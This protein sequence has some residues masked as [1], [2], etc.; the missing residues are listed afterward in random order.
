MV[1]A[2]MIE[3]PADIQREMKLFRMG[4]MSLPTSYINFHR[5][6]ALKAK[7][8]LAKTHTIH[9]DYM[10]KDGWFDGM[11]V[12]YLIVE[13]EGG[14]L[15]KLHWHDGSQTYFKE[16]K[17]GGSTPYH[18][19][20]TKQE[21]EDQL[22]ILSPGSVAFIGGVRVARNEV[23]F[24]LLCKSVPDRQLALGLLENW[25]GEEMARRV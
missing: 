20:P 10:A 22:T 3:L 16:C 17:Q 15:F 12:V 11:R 13:D 23:G 21:I 6:L 25:L 18:A 7:E 1:E 4:A 2:K 5:D 24:E 9:R 14:R 8:E 19:I